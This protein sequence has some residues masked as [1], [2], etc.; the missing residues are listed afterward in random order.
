M[1]PEARVRTDLYVRAHLRR[2]SAAG[3]A[4]YVLHRGDPDSGTLI[5]K[6]LRP[7]IGASVYSQTRDADGRAVW[8][9]VYPD[10]PV[11]EDQVDA[12]VARAAARDPD[13]WVVEIED[14]DGRNPFVDP[15][16]DR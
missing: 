9:S 8:L 10:G 14:R 3:I 4:A 6:L 11:P 7:G 12:Y 13:L 15:E 16:S 5:V 1:E 2:C